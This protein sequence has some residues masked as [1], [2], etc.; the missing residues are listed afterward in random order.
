MTSFHGRSHKSVYF[1]FH[2]RQNIALSLPIESLECV[3]VCGGVLGI[4][5]F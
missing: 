2:T 5:V 3:V 4:F 1:G